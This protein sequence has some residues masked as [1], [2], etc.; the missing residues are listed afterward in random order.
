MIQAV[1]TPAGQAEFARRLAGKPYFEAVMGTPRALFGNCPASGWRF[2]LLPGCAALS[3]RG[4]TATLCGALPG[5]PA[6][7]EAAEELQGFLHFLGVDRLLCET[8][9]LTVWKPQPALPLWEL[10]RGRQ[11]PLPAAPDTALTLEEH[12]AMLPVSRLVFADSEAEQEEFYSMACTAIAHGVGACHALLYRGQPVCTV[13]SYARSDSEAYMAAG[14]TAPDWRGRGLAGWL[15]VRL[16]NRLAQERTV[17][18]ASEPSL[19]DFY[20]RLGFARVG[21]IENY[22]QDW[23]QP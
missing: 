18:F 4:G 5:G 16:A 17:R 20:R 2:Y 15:I 21:F 3:L 1:T 8:M 22:T 9:P 14:V 13:G 12:P 19:T 6:G 7:E 23:N 10:A 11:L